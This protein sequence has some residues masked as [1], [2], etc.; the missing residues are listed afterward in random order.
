MKCILFGTMAAIV[1]SASAK[2]VVWYDMS[3]DAADGMITA[4]TTFTNIASP[5]NEFY[6]KI[7]YGAHPNCG[8]YT[9]YLPVATASFEEG[10]VLQDATFGPVKANPLAVDI[11]SPV[12]N[13]DGTA[14]SADNQ[15]GSAIYT[16]DP[17]KKLDLQTFTIEFFFKTRK[18]NNWHGLI[19]K[20]L[21]GTASDPRTTTFEIIEASYSQTQTRLS[22]MWSCRNAAGE[23]VSRNQSFYSGSTPCIQDGNWHHIAVTVDQASHLFSCYLDHRLAGTVSLPGDLVYGDGQDEQLAWNFGG[24]PYGDHA[25]G[26][27]IDEIR[28]SDRVLAVDEMLYRKAESAIDTNFTAWKA[29]VDGDWTD[30]AKWTD[31]APAAKPVR[32]LA[33]ADSDYTVTAAETEGTVL[34]QDLLMRNNG[35]GQVYLD[36]AS[37]FFLSGNAVATMYHSAVRVRENGVLRADGATYSIGSGSA[38]ESAGNLSLNDSSVSVSGTLKVTGGTTAVTNGTAGAV[39]VNGGGV[40]DLSGNTVFEGVWT[41]DG[42][43]GSPLGFAAGSALRASGNAVLD[44]QKYTGQKQQ[45]LTFQGTEMTF[46]DAAQL[47]V[48][49]MSISGTAGAGTTVT[50]RDQAKL[51]FNS[52]ATLSVGTGGGS[53]RLDLESAQQTIVPYGLYVGRWS[54]GEVNIR[55]GHYVQGNGNLNTVGAPVSNARVTGTVN[56]YDGALVDHHCAQ[57]GEVLYGLS[58]GD[59]MWQD[60]TS[61]SVFGRGILNIYPDG[62]VSNNASSQATIGEGVYLRVGSGRGEGDINIRGG[63]LSHNSRLQALVGVFGG[64]GRIT[65]TDGG[66]AEINAD[67]YVGGSVTNVLLGFRGTNKSGGWNGGAGFAKKFDAFNTDSVGTLAV[68]SGTFVCPSNL[69]VSAYGTGTLALGPSPD[70]QIRAKNVTL[71]NT[72]A[73]ATTHVSTLRFTAGATGTGC[74]MAD[75]TLTISEGTKLEIDLTALAD[76]K[77]TFF[78]LI[79]CAAREGDFA[80]AD[81]TLL[82]PEATG[83]GSGSLVWRTAKEGGLEFGF[84]VAR[85]TL[86][87]FR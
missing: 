48:Y 18:W 4:E 40:L 53:A 63:L 66:R 74:L 23:V 57:W 71:S 61:T 87:I 24:D 47:K 39:S 44:L 81:V 38:L 73:A 36:I 25:W 30:D 6:G 77:T 80:A 64:T 45:Q 50:F 19:C 32:I 68:E 12:F 17:E 76:T 7:G 79:R 42:A 20:P 72:V 83:F 84:G 14:V 46:R 31:G 10:I 69:Y 82:P 2:P 26:G 67:T 58:V 27:V 37:P 41:S 78:P 35:N 59:S 3:N 29:P 5:S 62:V 28:I 56:V 85:G 33:D 49:M 13:E 51:S 75:E 11:P 16:Y 34:T 60:L 52:D 8:S 9:K 21:S 55:G 70:A 43:V 22:L 15:K 54:T 1:V 86:V 65:I